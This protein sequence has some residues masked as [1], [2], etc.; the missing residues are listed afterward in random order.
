MVGRWQDGSP[1]VRY[2]RYPAT[3]APVPQHLPLSRSGV[4]GMAAQVLPAPAQ[5]V[6]VVRRRG[7]RRR[8][9]RASGTPH[10]PMAH[11]RANG[12]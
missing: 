4:G 8:E 3:D 2:P 1:L 9:S 5:N 7:Q 11:R 12:R 6:G 10:H